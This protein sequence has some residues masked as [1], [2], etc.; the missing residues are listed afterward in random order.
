MPT[1][2]LFKTN[3]SAVSPRSAA[4]TRPRPRSWEPKSMSKNATNGNGSNGE[5]ECPSCDRS[6]TTRKGLGNHHSAQHGMSIVDYEEKE[7]VEDV[8]CPACG[9]AYRSQQ[10]MKTHHKR[11][12]GKSIAGEPVV[13][14]QCG[15]DYRI[16]PA[17]VDHTRFCSSEC[18]QQHLKQTQTGEDNPCW[19]GGRSTFECGW[20]GESFREWDSQISGQY[21]FCNLQCYGE[22]RS[23]NRAGEDHPSWEGGHEFRDY[24]S[25]W[26]TQR[27]AALERDDYKCRGCG[28][29]NSESIDNLDI[30][31]HAHHIRKL[32]DFESP[33]QANVLNNL[34]TL[35]RTCHYRWEGIPLRPQ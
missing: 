26:A 15:D 28:M 17:R 30:A 13:C 25:N 23:A 9:E 22:W 4:G 29:A 31:L 18:R 20:C 6:F 5:C 33:E 14:E 2:I 34:L 19:K 10:A 3:K 16:V 35:C 27:R 7:V 8:E 11:K 32:S 12:H 21:A 1:K 24:G